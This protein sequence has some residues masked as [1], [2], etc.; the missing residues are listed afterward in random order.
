MHEL[1]LKIGLM[2][3]AVD[4]GLQ[5]IERRHQ[6]FGHVAAAECAETSLGVGQARRRGSSSQR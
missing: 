2:Q 5:P 1:R 4:A 6:R 3:I